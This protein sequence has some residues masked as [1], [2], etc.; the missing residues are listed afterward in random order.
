MIPATASRSLRRE[1]PFEQVAARLPD[2]MRPHLPRK[3]VQLGRVLLL[4]L[5]PELEEERQAVAAAYA[6]LPGVEAVM[7]R[8]RIGG[9]LRQPRLSQLLFGISAKTEVRE[10]GLRYRL[11]L[12]R[13]MWAPG[14]VGWRAGP[15]GPAAVAALY[16]HPGPRA[17][18]DC[19]AGVGYFALQF[20]RHW[21]ESQVIAVEKNPVAAGYLRRNVALNGLA[22]VEVIE[23]DCRDITREADIMHLG[24]IGDTVRFLSHAASQLRDGGAI[25]L[26]DAFRRADCGVRRS[27]DWA[28]VPER[29]RREL[30]RAAPGL[31]VARVARVKG[32]GPATAHLAIRLEAA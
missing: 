23:A 5:P 1:T 13:V 14:N 18:L 4:R 9:E 30:E 32:Y 15:R 27:R 8:P 2:W 21:P 11:D 31:R 29:L 28:V 25:I 7:R 3:W 22:N 26:H 20:A 19:F 17:I 24:Y 16:V 12:Q 6:T 10:H